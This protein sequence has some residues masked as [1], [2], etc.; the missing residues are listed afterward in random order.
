MGDITKVDM[1]D[2]LGGKIDDNTSSNMEEIE[3]TMHKVNIA[4]NFAVLMKTENFA[5]V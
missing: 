2:S 1:Y 3:V 5:L 4:E